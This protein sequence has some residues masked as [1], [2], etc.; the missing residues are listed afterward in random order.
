MKLLLHICCAP[1]LITPL[2]VLTGKDI[3]VSGY[4]YNN[5]IHPYTEFRK[6]LDALE[7]YAGQMS[8]DVIYDKNYDIKDYFMSVSEFDESRCEKCYLMRLGATARLA[9]EKGFD[10]FSTTLLYSKYQKHEI[11]KETCE[12]LATSYGIDFYY[13]DLRT[14]WGRG[15]KKSKKLLMYRQTYCGCIFSERDRYFNK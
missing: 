4:F 6:R 2:E 14:G 10:A 3:E 15:I 11:I 12:N 7:E 8:L 13:E 9:S 1:C 5:N